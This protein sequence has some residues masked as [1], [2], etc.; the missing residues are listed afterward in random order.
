MS[1]SLKCTSA[2]PADTQELA[3]AGTPRWCQHFYYRHLP[4]GQTRF[5]ML[6]ASRSSGF[7]SNGRS[8]FPAWT[9]GVL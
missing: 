7:R 6:S 4:A 1:I 2:L 9:L 8:S 3:P 5:R